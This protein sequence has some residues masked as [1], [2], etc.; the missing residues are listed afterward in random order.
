MQTKSLIQAQ[1]NI[2]T[3]TSLKKGDVF[4]IIEESSYDGTNIRYGIVTDLF[5]TGK[6]SFIE[7]LVY[8]KS[9]SSVEAEVKIIDGDK[10]LM[11]F[12]ATPEEIKD[13]LELTIISLEKDISSDKKALQ[14]KIES[15]E[16]AKTFVSGEASKKLSATSFKEVSQSEYEA[17]NPK[18]LNQ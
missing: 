9:Y 3:I 1:T 8:K 16:K 7:T 18:V 13:H 12:P 6:K 17:A 11:I 10:N 15:C 5:N 4:K 2:L 14:K